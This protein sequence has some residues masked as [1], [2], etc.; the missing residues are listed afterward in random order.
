MRVELDTA[1]AKGFGGRVL[2]K[3]VSGALLNWPNT[4]FFMYQ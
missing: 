4:D 3:S 1:V 2:D